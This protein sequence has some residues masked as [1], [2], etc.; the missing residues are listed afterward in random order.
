MLF[1]IILIVCIGFTV[2]AFYD[3][4]DH[5]FPAIMALVSWIGFIISLII[6]VG[7]NV[8]ISGQLKLYNERYNSLVYQLENNFYDNDN[9]LGLQELMKNIQLW[10]E[11]LAFNKEAQ[12]D[13]WIGIFYP[14]IY[15]EFDYIELP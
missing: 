6:V 7:N 11:D 13:F 9:D 1:W 12:D 3:D 8:N 15:D 4:G 10:N 2:W 5:I 14:D